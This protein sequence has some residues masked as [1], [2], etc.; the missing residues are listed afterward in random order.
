[1]LIAQVVATPL[2]GPLLFCDWRRSVSI[3]VASVPFA[4]LAGLLSSASGAQL[5]RGEGYALGWMGVVAIWSIA[6]TTPAA[7]G[8]VV[9]IASTLSLGATALLYVT[10]E[11]SDQSPRP[12]ALL[13]C[14][15]VA[16]VASQLGDRDHNANAAVAWMGIALLVSVVARATWVI[17]HRNS[18]TRAA[19]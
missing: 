19:T 5:A 4:C 2:L 9:A 3:A 8:S 10:A 6:A 14:N 17:L 7:K 16:G 1:M 11:F 18:A 13:R 15:P 12:L